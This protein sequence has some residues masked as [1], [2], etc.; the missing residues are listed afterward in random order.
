MSRIGANAFEH[1]RR[2]ALRSAPSSSRCQRDM[3]LRIRSHCIS[4]RRTLRCR[5][6]GLSRCFA[7][8]SQFE[9]LLPTQSSLSALCKNQADRV[10]TRVDGRWPSSWGPSRHFPPKI[11][12]DVALGGG[13]RSFG[14]M[15]G[16]YV[17]RKS[18]RPDPLIHSSNGAADINC[19]A[20]G[21][22]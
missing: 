21:M 14:A 10:E 12:S 4:A 6:N 7:V 3:S 16:F 19:D 20:V 5:R 1:F 18:T 11:R 13:D 17:V 2:A 15:R 8:M 9:S 22:G